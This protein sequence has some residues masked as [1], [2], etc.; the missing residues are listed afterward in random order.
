MKFRK[1]SNPALLRALNGIGSK[2]YD[3]AQ[4]TEL[5]EFLDGDADAAVE[6][7]LPEK[8]KPTKIMDF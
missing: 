7:V 3:P 1:K 8:T 6:S 2:R 4:D 5:M